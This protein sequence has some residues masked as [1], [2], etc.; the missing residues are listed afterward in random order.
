VSSVTESAPIRKVFVVLNPMRMV[1]P[2][3]EKAE[4]VAA[5]N[6]ASLHLYCCV[7]D[8][9]LAFRRESQDAAVEQALRWAE[10]I[11]DRP[12]ANG[13]GVE[14]QVEA[15]PDWREAMVEAAT[16]SGSDLIVKSL[17][18]H[19]A[20]TRRLAKTS[21]WGL[22]A[23]S[24]TPVLLVSPLVQTNTKTV[25]VAVKLKPG[26]D[27]HAE[28]NRRVLALAHRVSKALDAELHAVTVYK[29]DD[30]Y[31]DRQQFADSCGLPRNRVHSTEG[32]AQ[33]GI[34]EIAE[35]LNAGVIVIG[36]ANAVFGPVGADTAQRVI[37]EVH[38]DVIV[39]PAS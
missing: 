32:S 11:A 1:Q 16:G 39:L 33:R 15:H 4:W 10:R 27:V 8:T 17:S 25:L 22:L 13:I 31:F 14:I 38:A 28:L 36:S 21:D 5:R 19:G 34:A 3:L 23:A 9:H 20:L 30:I 6:K 29:G 7:Y 2:A 35:K 26:N 12:R 18:P 24:R 37:D